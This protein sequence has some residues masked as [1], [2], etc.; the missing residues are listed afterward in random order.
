MKLVAK[1]Q[2]KI[3]NK[4]QNYVKMGTSEE[5]CKSLGNRRKVMKLWF[6]TLQFQL[7]KK[8]KKQTK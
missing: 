8:I 7:K 6:I 3:Q 2:Y 1:E 5:N 4:M